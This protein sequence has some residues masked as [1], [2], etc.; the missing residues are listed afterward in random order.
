MHIWSKSGRCE[1]KSAGQNRD[2]NPG[3][4]VEG[5]ESLNLIDIL[6]E[7]SGIGVQ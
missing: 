2:A 4:L 5:V 1:S 6:N 7:D 3:A